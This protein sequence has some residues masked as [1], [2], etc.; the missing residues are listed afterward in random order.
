[1]S[2]NIK[3]TSTAW[4]QI[5]DMWNVYFTPPSRISDGELK[6]YKQWLE[7][8]NPERKPLNALVL[9]ATPELR[10]IL[11]ELGYKT[12]IIDI[13]LEMILAMNSV[14][15][16]ENPIET[17]IK[18]NWLDNP[19][20][21]DYFDVVLGD[22]VLPNIPWSDRKHLLLEVKRT[23]KKGGVFLNRSFCMPKKKPFSDLDALLKHFEEKEPSRKTSL[24]F[25]LELQI[26]AYDPTDHLGTFSKP[27]EIIEELG[28]DKGFNFESKN[29]NKTLE[30]TWDFWCKK[31]S[32]KVFVYAYRDEEEA[33]LKK[34]FEIKE[35]FEAKDNPYSKITPM[36][37]LEKKA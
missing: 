31:F 13:N 10:D 9:G 34:F 30:M 12:S 37:I 33:E 25:V 19:L 23:L 18:S 36:Y 28:G 27:K 29:L 2:E 15:K 22:A 4:K 14:M 21:S 32:N 24:E 17:I 8:L 5:A 20:Q 3:T 35:T 1:M 7:V 26:L 11:Y 6:K 16:T